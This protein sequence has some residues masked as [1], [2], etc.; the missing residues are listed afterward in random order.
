MSARPNPIRICLVTLIALLG[1]LGGCQCMYVIDIPPETKEAPPDAGKEQIPQEEPDVPDTKEPVPEPPVELGPEPPKEPEPP[2]ENGQSEACQSERPGLCGPGVRTCTD[3]QW[4]PCVSLQQPSP[5]LCDGLDNDCDGKVDNIEGTSQQLFKECYPSAT[6]GCTTAAGTYRCQGLCRAG[7]QLCTQGQWGSCQQPI[8]PTEEIC[9]DGLDNDCDGEIDETCECAL[10]EN[11][12]CWPGDA[13]QCPDGKPCNGICKRGIQGCTSERKWGV[14]VGATLSQPEVCNG[15]DDDCD[16][17]IDN[18]K[19]SPKPLEQ[20]CYS[21]PANT[22][23]V[24]ECKDGVQRCI[25]GTWDACTGDTLPTVEKFCGN[26][27]PKDFNC[28][29]IPNNFKELGK[30]C[31]DPTRKGICRPGTW[32]CVNDA[33]A[34]AANETPRKEECNN[35]D[36]DCDGTIDEALIRECPYSGPPGTQNVGICKAAK[37]S[38]SQGVWGQCSGEVIPQQET[39][40][41]VDDNCNGTL[42]EFVPLQQVGK[43][44]I[45]T[46][47]GSQSHMYLSATNTGY[48]LGWSDGQSQNVTLALTKA[49]G[50]RQAPNIPVTKGNEFGNIHGLTFTGTDIVVTWDSDKDEIAGDAHI[51]KLD[52]NGKRLIGPNIMAKGGRMVNPQVTTGPGFLGVLWSDYIKN[53]LQIQTLD[54]NLK[55]IGTTPHSFPLSTRN[56]PY[57]GLSFSG[58]RLATVWTTSQNK[59][60]IAVV[61]KN[62]KKLGESEIPNAGTNPANATIAGDK[63]GFLVVWSDLSNGKLLG[64]RIDRNAKPVGQPLTIAA[65]GAR[66]PIMKATSY[67]GL[68]AWIQRQNGQNGVSIAWVDNKGTL[69]AKPSWFAVSNIVD[70]LALAWRDT[71][72]GRGRG[73]IAWM[74]R[75]N[76]IRL[77]PLGCQLVAP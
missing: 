22:R 24:G 51:L 52:A 47:S 40:N 68:I 61:D 34:C 11:Q 21:G 46:Q 26:A 20:A 19:S 33:I 39:C 35:L 8:R 60:K 36:D 23:N 9:N 54:T 41:Y 30:P 29:G 44:T 16:G 12:P 45:Y 65:Q 2:C 15:K 4:G 75:F 70:Y 59:L 74:D 3:N 28:D 27:S 71:A 43:A 55:P 25:N 62:N 38:C 6:R 10:G 77:A 56:S 67:G 72:Q 64:Q 49:D 37:Q 17:L 5:E 48:V 42:D 58:D 7:K 32:K 13:L 53:Q 66:T 63:T 57:P 1:L 18:Q 73:A 69:L 76:V 50:T 31:T 14:C